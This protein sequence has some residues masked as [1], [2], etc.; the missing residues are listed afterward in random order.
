MTV[1]G[2][3]NNSLLLLASKKKREI[4]AFLGKKNLPKSK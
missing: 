3:E 4:K 1:G 2:S